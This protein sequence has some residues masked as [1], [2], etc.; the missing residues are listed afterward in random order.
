MSSKYQNAK[1]YKIVGK[2]FKKCYIGS[3]VET[4][5]LSHR[6]A[7]HR[8]DYKKWQNGGKGFYSSFEM[9]EE[10]GVENVMMVLIEKFPCDDREDLTAREGHHIKNNE[11]INK[12]IAGRTDREY[13]QDNREKILQQV[14]DYNEANKEHKNEYHN[15]YSQINKDKWK[16]SN[17]K[18]R[19]QTTCDCG[20][21]LQKKAMS[22]HL[23]SKQHQNYI[24]QMNQ[25]EPPD[26]S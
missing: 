19:Q 4:L 26:N 14:K 5:S 23:K 7:K 9:F 8:F 22:K 1:V 12:R 16:Q 20:C 15:N 25:Q 10:F 13:Y 3:T 2:G 11:C 21:V 18:Q 17:E 6:M 24:N